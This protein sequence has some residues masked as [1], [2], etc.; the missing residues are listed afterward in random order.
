MDKFSGDAAKIID[1]LISRSLFCCCVCVCVCVC[2]G[3]GGGGGASSDF[4]VV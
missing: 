1:Q 4:S 3:G 2:G